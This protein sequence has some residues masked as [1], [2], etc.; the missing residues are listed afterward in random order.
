MSIRKLA[1]GALLLDGGCSSGGHPP[2]TPVAPATPVTVLADSDVTR[3]AALLAMADARE[4]DSATLAAGLASRSWPIRVEAV[5]AVGQM[6]VRALAPKLRLLLRDRDTSVA[7][8]AAFSLGLMRDSASVPALAAVLGTGAGGGPS[9]QPA[10]SGYYRRAPTLSRNVGSPTVVREAAWALGQMGDAG[11]GPLERV[12]DDGFAPPGVLYAAA[13]LEPVPVEALTAYFW[14][15]NPGVMRAAVYAVTRSRNAAGV[16]ALLNAVQAPDPITRSYV[17]RGLARSAAG[18]SLGKYAFHALTG[19]V[20]DSAAVVRIEALGSLRG[21]GPPAQ[22][23][24]LQATHDS[25]GTVRLAAAHALDSAL[26]GAPEVLWRRA[27]QADTALAYHAAV[28][29]AAVRAGVVLPVLDPTSADRWQASSDWRYRAAAARAGGELPLD[30]ALALVLPGTRDPDGRVR[31]VAVDMIAGAMDSAGASGRGV[32][33][34]YTQAWIR[35]PDAGVRAAWLEALLRLGPRADDVLA[36]AESYR[37]ATQDST[38]DARLAAVRYI[39]IVWRRDSA[40]V[41]AQARAVVAALPA[42]ADQIVLDSA[43]GVSVFAT[44]SAKAR[45]AS[46]HPSGWYERVVREVVVPSLSGRAPTVAITTDRGVLT[47]EL[48]GADAP[49]TVEN[50]LSLMRSGYYAGTVFHRVVP[51]FVVQDGDRRGDGNGGPGYTIRDELGRRHYERG[52]LG[53]ALSGPETGGSQYFVTII[54]EPHLDGRYSAFG[55]MIRGFDALDHLVPGDRIT[56]I[57]LVAQQ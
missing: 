1:L 57:S 56:E 27:F 48:Y 36:V 25:I 19:L 24:V 35:D 28:A 54:P 26:A 14:P 10:T 22:E 49:L 41:G 2:A 21:Y 31:A 18:D 5:R 15:G 45:R 9:P 30:R 55:R 20:G 23:L 17:A 52:T 51:G 12:I 13:R 40:S 4:P 53:M 38:V 16:R 43:R 11:R 33:E 6:R 34:R 32:R 42:P 3:Y 8:A 37:M 7:A 44:W 46:P 47:V 29:A 50:F 39:A